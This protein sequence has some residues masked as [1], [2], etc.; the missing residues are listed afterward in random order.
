MNN[1]SKVYQTK[2]MNWVSWI[3]N[4]VDEKLSLRLLSEFCSSMIF[5]FSI[6][7]VLALGEL[8]VPVFHFFYFYNI[9]VGL[10]I[11]FTTML[12]FHW[13][14]K[15][16]ISS[17]MIN[18]AWVHR[19]GEITTK[20]FWTS[21]LFQFIGG[22]LGALAVFVII[23]HALNEHLDY[24]W[25]TSED[26][27]A[28]GGAMPKLKGLFVNTP[29]EK[30]IFNP[31]MAINFAHSDQH[32]TS[33]VY[34]FAVIQ[35]FINGSWIIIAFLLNSIVNNKTKTIYSEYAFR[36]LIL[37]IGVSVT[38]IFSA[39]TTN[40]IRLLSPAIVNFIMGETHGALIMNTTLVYIAIQFIG[41]AIVYFS[42]VLRTVVEEEVMFDKEKI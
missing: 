16:T 39:N 4:Q 29:V 41:V 15:T 25:T 31:W 14:R 38:T 3:E 36:F 2:K 34:S 5:I 10:W 22:F 8:E 1:T 17:T 20:E 28:M 30:S 11:G 18:L 21:L 40:W 13:S 24:D 12:I 42:L 6:N 26:V 33:F 19:R 23:N 32:S 7:I 27:Y 35:G 37:V 9:G